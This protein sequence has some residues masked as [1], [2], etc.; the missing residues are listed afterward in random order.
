MAV[1]DG[2]GNKQYKQHE[3]YERTNEQTTKTN[4]RTNKQT[5][6]QQP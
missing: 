6:K 5:N 1:S 4:K 2:S 3:Q